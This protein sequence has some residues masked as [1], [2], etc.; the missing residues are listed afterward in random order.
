M[1]GPR[2]LA[3]AQAAYHRWV[4]TWTPILGPHRGECGLCGAPDARHR[5]ADAM[6][7]RYQAGDDLTF[8][9]WDHELT[10]PAPVAELVAAGLAY[11]VAR[12]RARLPRSHQ[13]EP[14]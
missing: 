4:E 3:A 8:I 2:R 12:R 6:V 10:D 7:E 11:E 13:P 1:T 14:P 9:A 5:T